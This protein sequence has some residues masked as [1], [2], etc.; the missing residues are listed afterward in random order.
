MARAHR[1]SQCV[2]F[3]KLTAVTPHGSSSRSRE[4]E[5]RYLKRCAPDWSETILFSVLYTEFHELMIEDDST[6]P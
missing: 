5:K 3:R 6:F 2:Q 4:A 1:E